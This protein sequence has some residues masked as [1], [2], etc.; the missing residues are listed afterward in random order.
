MVEPA[1]AEQDL[2]KRYAILAEGEAWLIDEA[3]VIPFCM[4]GGGYVASYLN[5]FESQYAPF[6]ASENRYK[7]QWIYE[8]PF[9]MDEY[10]Q[11]LSDW[12]AER[13]A[14][15]AAGK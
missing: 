8:T 10:A 11:L 4:D 14:L 1:F 15:L 5:P 13:D 12:E 9:G 7:Y 6:G 3:Y 2:S